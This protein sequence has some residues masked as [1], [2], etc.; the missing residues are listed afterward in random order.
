MDSFDAIDR[1]VK[2]WQG[3]G[4]IDMDG[5][6][7]CRFP[8]LVSFASDRGREAFKTNAT[9]FRNGTDDGKISLEEKGDLVSESYPL[10][11]RAHLMRVALTRRS[12]Q[13]C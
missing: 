4:R 9:I 7:N 13:S 1:F 12:R 5:H 10:D 6:G 2:Y 11:F 8:C 3:K